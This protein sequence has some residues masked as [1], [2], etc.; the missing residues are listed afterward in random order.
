MGKHL[1]ELKLNVLEKKAFVNRS[2]TVKEVLE[3]AKEGKTLWLND[4]HIPKV[5][6]ALKNKIPFAE[7]AL[8]SSLAYIGI[9][10]LGYGIYDVFFRSKKTKPEPPTP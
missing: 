7:Q 1:S 6:E 4:A 8:K 10:G 3:T 9:L 2:Y 5:L